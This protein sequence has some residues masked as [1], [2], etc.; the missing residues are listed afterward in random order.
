MKRDL[1]LTLREA[2]IARGINPENTGYKVPKQR[3]LAIDRIIPGVAD[4]KSPS[5]TMEACHA[6]AMYT[7]NAAAKD[8]QYVA[9]SDRPVTAY[10]R[11]FCRLNHLIQG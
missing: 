10:V 1:T 7:R 11:A 3:M 8:A 6:R 5:A 9:Q 2:C 4:R